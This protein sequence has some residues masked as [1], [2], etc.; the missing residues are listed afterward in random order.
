MDEPR[1]GGLIDL[2]Y[3]FS[4]II[5]VMVFLI[6]LFLALFLLSRAIP[7]DYQSFC[8][9]DSCSQEA[10]YWEI[11]GSRCFDS[12]NTNCT[13]FLRLWNHCQQYKKRI[14]VC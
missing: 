7:S 14:G 5:F 13:D 6:A 10:G 4:W 11:N 2:N 12:N 9:Y 1:Y 8:D 3:I